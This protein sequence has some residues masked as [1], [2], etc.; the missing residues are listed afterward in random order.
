M[1]ARCILHEHVYE[2]NPLFQSA[3][4]TMLTS[5]TTWKYKQINT[6][7]TT[8]PNQFQLFHDSSRQQYGYVHYSIELTAFPAEH[9]LFNN[10]NFNLVHRYPLSANLTL[11]IAV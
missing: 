10:C 5:A 3:I 11:S 7:P 9:T 4:D 2:Q 8:H 6:P 1:M